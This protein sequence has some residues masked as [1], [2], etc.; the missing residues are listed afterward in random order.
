MKKKHL[1][2]ILQKI[3]TYTIPDPKLEQYLTPA[4][5]AAD[6]IFKAYHFGDI[7]NKK[8]IDLGCGTGIFSVGAIILGAKKVIG[9]DIDK[10]SIEIAQK[11]A[12]EN[13]LNIEFYAINIVDVTGKF[14]TI[15]MNPPFGSQK[16]NKKADRKFI[17]KG[18]E[19]GSII[20]SIHLS[21]TI[22]FI[23]KL[24][25][26][27]GGTIDYSNDYIFPIKW[28]YN[29]HKKETENFNVTL[30]RINTNR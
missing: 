29:F 28:M 3:P 6:I 16:S 2:L 25:K 1:E 23:T 7:E 10:N 13:R 8:I 4:S 22:D 24:I 21:Q 5:I 12:K 18:F 15:I 30:L 17:E 9:I 11:Y 14:D 20:Y 27:L 19:I 26:A